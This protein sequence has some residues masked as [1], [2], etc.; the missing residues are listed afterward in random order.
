M[1]LMHME[2]LNGDMWF[3]YVDAD[4]HVTNLLPMMLLEDGFDV[5]I[6]H[7]RATYWGHGHVQHTSTDRVKYAS[8]SLSV[9]QTSHALKCEYCVCEW[10]ILVNSCARV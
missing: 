3:Q 9:S 2:F 4:G 1:L 8:L 6:G 10:E 5:W 7:Q